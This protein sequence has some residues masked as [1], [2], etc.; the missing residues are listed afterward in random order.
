VGRY[1]CIEK[2]PEKD[3]RAV[4]LNCLVSGVYIPD[5]TAETDAA[6]SLSYTFKV[7]GVLEEMNAAVVVTVIASPMAKPPGPSVALK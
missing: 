1:T 6:E 3:V 2:V 5:Q 4:N 7:T